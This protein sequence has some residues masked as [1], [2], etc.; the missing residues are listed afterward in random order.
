MLIFS[1]KEILMI[2]RRATQFLQSWEAGK[3]VYSYQRHIIFYKQRE[4]KKEKCTFSYF[5]SVVSAEGG[6]GNISII[7]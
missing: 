5:P 2:K 6:G 3:V 1:S 7:L 4:N